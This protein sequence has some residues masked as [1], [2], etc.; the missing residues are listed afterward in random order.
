MPIHHPGQH[1]PAPPQGAPSLIARDLTFRYPDG[2]AALAGVTFALRP[3]ERVALV[4]PNGAGKSTLLLNLCG[5]L[6]GEGEVTVAGLRLAPANLSRIRAAV[7]LVFQD[8]NDQLF[9][10]TVFEDVAFG[11]LHMGLDEGTVRARADAALEAVGMRGF[12]G[13]MPHHLSVGQ[14]KRVSV[15]TVLAMEP[16]IL[17]L[18]EPSAGL[19]PRGRRQLITLLAS[20]PQTMLIST[21]DMRLV[22]ALCPRTLVLDGG[23]LVADGATATILGDSALLEAHGLEKP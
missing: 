17:L 8:P 23:R 9:S 20:L 16:H 19:D 22:D 7:G 2:F 1:A 5:L 21:H 18:D 3:G 10:P 11:P 13:R 14:M 4:G 6:A 12:E 15:A